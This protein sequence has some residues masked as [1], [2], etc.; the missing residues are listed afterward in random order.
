[1][2]DTANNLKATTRNAGAKSVVRAVRREGLVPGVVYG[3][4]IEGVLVSVEPRE[5][6]RVLTTD[7]AY[8]AAFDL[9]IDGKDTHKVMVREMQF[10]SVRRVVTHVDFKV[11]HDDERVEIDV[12]V[13]T[14]GTA[15]GVVEGGRLD[16][17]RRAVKIVTTV[18]NIPVAVI[19]DVTPLKIGDQIYIDEMEAPEGSSFLFNHRYPVI[20]VARRRVVVDE[21]AKPLDEDG[22]PI[23][24]EDE[25]E[26]GEEG[27]G[28]GEE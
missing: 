10:D 27:E 22:E 3:H 28:E 5:L 26:E 7:Y 24:D 15:K 18:S 19:Q 17:V 16:I 13:Q 23:E 8:N 14:T 1:M 2:A 12:P 11:V 21:D 20:R 25:D 4:D 9:E 6:E